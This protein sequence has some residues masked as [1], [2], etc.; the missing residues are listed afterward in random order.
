MV[1]EM[2]AKEAM[3]VRQW[4]IQGKRE[5]EGYGHRMQSSLIA[6]AGDWGIDKI[7]FYRHH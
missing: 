4:Q 2:A 7:R 5:G 1:Y 6:A 3:V